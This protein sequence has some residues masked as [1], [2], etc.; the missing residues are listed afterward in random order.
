MRD[1]RKEFHFTPKS[2]QYNC[3]FLLK[4]A[5]SCRIAGRLKNVGELDEAEKGND[6]KRKLAYKRDWEISSYK[7]ITDCY[8][9][10]LYHPCK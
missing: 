9:G 7:V 4:V 5:E 8:P 10:I 3:E 1:L 2:K 6:Q